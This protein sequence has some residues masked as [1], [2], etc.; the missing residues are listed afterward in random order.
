MYISS[1]SLRELVYGSDLDGVL[2]GYYRI[3]FSTVC[4][5]QPNATADHRTY[6]SVNN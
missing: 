2:H 3:N 5:K 4:V 6:E 1:K